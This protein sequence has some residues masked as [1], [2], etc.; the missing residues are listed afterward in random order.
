MEASTDHRRLILAV[1]PGHLNCGFVVMDPTNYEM[2]DYGVCSINWPQNQ[3]VVKMIRAIVDMM[4]ELVYKYPGIDTFLIEYQ[5]PPP[6]FSL[7]LCQQESAFLSAA[8]ACGISNI[9]QI[10]PMQLKCY[11]KLGC[12]GNY[13]NKRAAE[14]YIIDL[15]YEPQVSHI[16]DCILMCLFHLGY[17]RP[18][19][20]NL[21]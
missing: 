8:L 12:R 5:P 11:F 4:I 19:T 16:A 10:M 1:D 15:G 21:I 7:R 6:N 14:A 17:Q 9:A 13:Q 18:T 3:P 20:I 2:V